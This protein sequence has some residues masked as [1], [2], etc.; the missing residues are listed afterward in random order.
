M[1]PGDTQILTNTRATAV[2]R[3]WQPKQSQNITQPDF[4]D[5]CALS[6]ALVSRHM[7]NGDAGLYQIAK[8]L[9]GLANGKAIPKGFFF[10][11]V[12]V[13]LIKSRVSCAVQQ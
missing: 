10:F 1:D 7:E 11:V 12:V 4:V 3:F 5:I 13:F 2:D 8:N 9:S 6:K